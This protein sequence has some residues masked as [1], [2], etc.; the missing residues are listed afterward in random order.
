MKRIVLILLLFSS[1]FVMGLYAEGQNFGIGVIAGEPTG[2]SAKMYLGQNEAVDAAA[3][4]SFK[5]EIIYLHAD[6]LHHFPGALGKDLKDFTLYAG[7]GGLLQL[8]NTSAFGARVPV[9]INYFLPDFPL[10]IFIEIGPAIL[11]FPETEFEF[12]GG[13]GARY[14]W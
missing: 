5:N 10:E 8:G 13:I 14:Y 12:T 7:I 11:L 1:L 2:I 9:G 6:Y 4:W 3:S